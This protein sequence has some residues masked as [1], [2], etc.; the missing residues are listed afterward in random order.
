MRSSLRY[1]LLLGAATL[2]TNSLRGQAPAPH[3]EL[4]L[5][6]TSV[7]QRSNITPGNFFWRQGGALELSTEVHR[8]FGV[9]VN[10]AGSKASNILG[11]GI[12]LDTFTVTGG[13][14][15]T[16]H[17]SNGRVSAFGQALFGESHGW[18]SLFPKM[19]GPTSSANS[20]AMQLGGGVDV[21]VSHHFAVRAVQ[22]DW[23]RTQFP[24]ATT[25][26]QNDLR[27][28]AGIVVRLFSR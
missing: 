10:L 1:L 25:D 5:A 28:G 20:F 19:G 15:Y 18:N 7:S 17:Q 14:R 3:R 22:A 6:V 23:V 26:R 12:D 24:N 9:A 8:G 21:N 13:P 2:T 11:T 4:D 27:L 16:W